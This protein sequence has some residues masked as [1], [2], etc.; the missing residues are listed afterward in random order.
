MRQEH[1]SRTLCL[2][3]VIL[4]SIAARETAESWSDWMSQ[5]KGLYVAGNYADAAGAFRQALSLVEF[6]ETGYARR[7]N[8]LGSL[9][10]AY[11]KLGRV[12]DAE[13]AYRQAMLLVEQNEGRDSLAYA[14]VLARMTTVDTNATG[15]REAIGP[16]SK[17]LEKYSRTSPT[18]SLSTIRLCLAR[19]LMEQKRSEEAERLLLDLRR[20][21]AKGGGAD[22]FSTSA[23]VSAL[24]DLRFGQGR[25]SESLELYRE[26]LHLLEA[27]VGNVH[28][29]LVSVLG[30]IA[31]SQTKMGRFDDAANSLERAKTVYEKALGADHPMGVT[32][33]L[34]YAAVLQKMGRK[35]EAREMKA[36]ATQILKAST[37]RNGFG[38]TVGVSA[39]SNGRP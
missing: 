32:L 7:V 16:L 21:L 19:I 10:G 8:S 5:G 17:A 33:L 36:R 22:V 30:N 2:L 31:A 12:V 34:N 14:S 37:R 29:T 27:A 1:I 13:Y 23:A 39:L 24:G 15:R 28:A 20:D 25:Y 11:Q 35:H 9:A 18:V 26:S 4:Q 3:F 6:A 38:S